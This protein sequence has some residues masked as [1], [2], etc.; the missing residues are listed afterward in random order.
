[1]Y[2]ILFSR[3]STQAVHVYCMS[4][5]DIPRSRGQAVEMN[6]HLRQHLGEGKGGRERNRDRQR[7]G[8]EREGLGQRG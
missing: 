3:P 2:N 4:M 1:M 6:I 8:Q 5:S 7:R